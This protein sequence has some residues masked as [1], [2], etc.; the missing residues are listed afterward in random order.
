MHLQLAV[1][2]SIIKLVCLP[3]DPVHSLGHCIALIGGRGVRRPARAVEGCAARSTRRRRRT[4]SRRSRCWPAAP[5][6][7]TCTRPIRQHLHAIIGKETVAEYCRRGLEFVIE[8]VSSASP[9]EENTV[10][11]SKS[12]IDVYKAV[13]LGTENTC[14]V[15]FSSDEI[16]QK[17]LPIVAATRYLIAANKTAI[18]EA[19]ASGTVAPP[20]QPK[21]YEV[22][23][24]FC[25]AIARLSPTSAAITVITTTTSENKD[26]TTASAASEKLARPTKKMTHLLALFETTL[27]SALLVYQAKAKPGE[28]DVEFEYAQWKLLDASRFAVFMNAGRAGSGGPEAFLLRAGGDFGVVVEGGDEQVAIFEELWKAVYGVEREKKVDEVVEEVVGDF[29]VAAVP[30]ETAGSVESSAA[31]G[32][33]EGSEEKEEKETE[34]EKEEKAKEVEEVVVN[35]KK[36]FVA[37]ATPKKGKSAA[38]WKQNLFDLLGDEDE[39]E[40]EEE[41]D[42]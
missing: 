35:K 1:T 14:N 37:P 13:L 25:A 11:Y 19:A 31:D 22:E 6:A 34:A 32:N 29:A 30:E 41:E 20:Q 24:L 3:L 15:E 8:N 42:E 4:S 12:A 40:G 26:A 23:A 33:N 28:I 10:D 36:G 21:D 38:G 18:A 16:A 2:T 9:T 17:Y 39:D 7:S 5:P 27:L